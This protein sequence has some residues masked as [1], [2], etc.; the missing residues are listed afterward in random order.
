MR[1]KAHTNF[2]GPMIRT[3]AMND[4]EVLG[5]HEHLD[6]KC[7]LALLSVRFQAISFLPRDAFKFLTVSALRNLAREGRKGPMIYHSVLSR[8]PTSTSHQY[9]HTSTAALRYSFTP[10]RLDNKSS[11]Y[12]TKLSTWS[13]TNQASESKTPF[14]ESVPEP[15][16]SPGLQ[17]CT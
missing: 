3:C 10:G 9:L 4:E 1:S 6:N 16:P 11:C 12:Q 7:T 17:A 15:L 2:S 5:P 13:I 14:S 8:L